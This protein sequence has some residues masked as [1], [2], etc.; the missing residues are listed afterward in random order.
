L[1]KVRFERGLGCF[2]HSARFAVI[3]PIMSPPPVVHAG[4]EH[5]PARAYVGCKCSMQVCHLLHQPLIL[6]DSSSLCNASYQPELYVPEQPEISLKIVAVITLKYVISLHWSTANEENH[7]SCSQH[8]F[9]I[10]HKTIKM[11]FFV[12]Y[13]WGHSEVCTH[14]HS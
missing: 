3:H 5:W 7:V 2:F 10:F 14:E 6:G 12:L 9:I 11:T 13:V 8:N 1:L 4:T